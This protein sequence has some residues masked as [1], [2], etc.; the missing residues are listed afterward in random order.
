MPYR[1]GDEISFSSG[2]ANLVG[3]SGI[4]GFSG[5]EP[6]ATWTDGGE[7]VVR[8]EV[9]PPDSDVILEAD[10]GAFFPP[11][12]TGQKAMIYVNSTPVGEWLIATGAFATKRM[13]IPQGVIGAGGKLTLRF[14]ISHPASP[15]D[16]GLGGNDRRKLGLCFSTLSLRPA[17]PSTDRP[18]R[19]P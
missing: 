18:P 8:L 16:N 12:V 5:A 2:S 4:S 6:K 13:V 14:A 10:L 17:R 9:S 3:S 7:A 19:R 11:Q 15:A 1:W